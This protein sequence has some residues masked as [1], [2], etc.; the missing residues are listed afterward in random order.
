MADEKAN[1]W[2]GTMAGATEENKTEA[3]HDGAAACEAGAEG[4]SEDENWR[5]NRDAAALARQRLQAEANAAKQPGTLR[6]DDTEDRQNGAGTQA[7][8]ADG[9]EVV[10][11]EGAGDVSQ[12]DSAQSA[13]ERSLAESAALPEAGENLSRKE[14]R[15]REKEEKERQK[16]EAQEEKERLKREEQEEKERKKRE[17]QEAKERAKREAQEEK[18]RQKR[19]AEEERQRKL[20]EKKEA[21]SIVRQERRQ[22]CK[23]LWHMVE[24]AMLVTFIVLAIDQ[25]GVYGFLFVWLFVA[26][27]IASIALLLL[28]IVRAIRKKRCGIIFFVAVVGIIGC[29]AWFIFLVSSQGLGLGPV[30]N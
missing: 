8:Q 27:M 29:T 21:K 1:E 24:F 22:E 7:E 14:R 15:Q 23:S 17:E 28:G 26:L 16:R 5:M 20:H 6:A 3:V 19:L 12:A 25:A 11:P 13:P 2:D 18:E 30:P 10:Q 9:T 4:A